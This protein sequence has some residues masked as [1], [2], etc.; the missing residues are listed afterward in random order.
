MENLLQNL[1][2]FERNML[3]KMKSQ[4]SYYNKDI[5]SSPVLS[6]IEIFGGTLDLLGT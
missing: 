2:G 4:P 6:S 1:L 5:S 3:W